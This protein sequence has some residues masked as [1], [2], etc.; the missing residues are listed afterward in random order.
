M[1]TMQTVQHHIAGASETAGLLVFRP[2]ERP[3]TQLRQAPSPLQTMRS[4]SALD[5]LRRCRTEVTISAWV[6][7]I[8]SPP[9]YP[10]SEPTDDFSLHSPDGQNAW[11]LLKI[12]TV[13]FVLSERSYRDCNYNPVGIT[14]ARRKR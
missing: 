3:P 1:L 7:V 14:R 13:I 2:R 11:A 9:K 5:H 10:L 8:G 4:F 6:F 12:S